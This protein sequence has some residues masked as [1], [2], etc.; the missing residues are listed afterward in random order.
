MH[1]RANKWMNTHCFDVELRHHQ[2]LS[3]VPSYL[4]PFSLSGNFASL[5]AIDCGDSGSVRTLHARCMLDVTVIIYYTVD[6]ELKNRVQARS[7][8]P[9]GFLISLVERL[10][11]SKGPCVRV[12][13]PVYAYA[14]NCELCKA[15]KTRRLM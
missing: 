13:V 7:P 11:Y 12:Y 10:I 9:G 5:P 2:T 1:E 15:K 8:P 4:G 6:V 3:F 14:S